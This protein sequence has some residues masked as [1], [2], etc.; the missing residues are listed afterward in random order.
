MR[1]EVAVEVRLG[2]VRSGEAV[3]AGLGVVSQ[4]WERQSRQGG[5]RRG[6]VGSGAARQSANG[7][8]RC[9]LARNGSQG[10]VWCVVAGAWQGS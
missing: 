9:G 1:L 10:S 6:L 4:A 7:R 8:V 3:K 5:V 2:G